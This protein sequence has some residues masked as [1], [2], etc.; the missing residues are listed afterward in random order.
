MISTSKLKIYCNQ[1]FDKDWKTGLNNSLKCNTYIMFK[2]IPKPGTYQSQVMNRKHGI[3][4]TKLR[5]SNYKLM[6]EE[7]RKKGP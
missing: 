4:L 6:I 1:L 5:V 7:G 3:A 2:P